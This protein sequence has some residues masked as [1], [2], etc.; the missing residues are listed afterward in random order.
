MAANITVVSPWK[1]SPVISNK[2]SPILS[3]IGDRINVR[4]ESEHEDQNDAFEIPPVTDQ[5]D[6]GRMDY[7]MMKQMLDQMQKLK[8]ESRKQ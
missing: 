8:E 7:Q 2:N 5:V 1:T 3:C 4:T 6:E